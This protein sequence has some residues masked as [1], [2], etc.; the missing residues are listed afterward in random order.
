MA[1]KFYLNDAAASYNPGVLKGAWND[2][3]DSG[4]IG[5]LGTS[6]SGAYVTLGVAETNTSP[7]WNVYLASFVS[8]ALANNV[9]FKTTDTLTG[10]LAV[11]VSNAAAL[12]VTHIHIWVTVGNSDTVRGT[13]LNDSIGSSDWPT[14]TQGLSLGTLNL[15]NNVNALTGDHIVVEIGY[16]AQNTVATSYTGTLGFGANSPANPDLTNGDTSV[17]TNPSWIQFST[18]FTSTLTFLGSSID[19]NS[20]PHSVTVTP[21]PNDLIVIVTTATNNTSN[22]VP[23]DDNTHGGVYEQITNA[24]KNNGVDKLAAYVRTEFIQYT[25]S[26]TFTHDPGTSSGG[27]IAVYAIRGSAK[28]GLAAIKQSIQDSNKLSATPSP[29]LGNTPVSTNPVLSAVFNNTNPGGVTARTGYTSDLDTGYATPTSGFDSIHLNSGETSATIT[30]GSSSASNYC[31]LA[32]EFDMSVTLLENQQDTFLGETIL[33]DTKWYDNTQTGGIQSV[34]ST[35]VTLNAPAFTGNALAEVESQ[36]RYDLTGSHAF[37]KATITQVADVN[38]EAV[39]TI[40]HD[41]YG[42]Q[43]QLKISNSNLVAGYLIAG[44]ETDVGTIAY[45]ATTMAY[46]RIRESSGTIYWDYSADGVTW[47]N[48]GS[49]ATSTITW[50][51]TLVRTS[52]ATYNGDSSSTDEIGIFSNF[53]IA[54]TVPTVVTNSITSI[55]QLDAVGNGDV[56]LDGGATITERGF[57]LSTITN[58]TTSDTKFVVTGTTG[59]FTISLTPLLSDTVYH[60]RAY[61]INSQGTSYGADVAFNT[62]SSTVQAILNPINGIG[63][64]QRSKW[65]V[66]AWVNGQLFADLTGIANDRHLVLIRNDSDQIDFSMNLDQLEEYARDIKVNSQDILQAGITEIRFLRNGTVISAGY[67]TYWDVELAGDRKITIQA[68]GWLEKLKYRISNNQYSSQTALQIFQAEVN[69]TQALA[70]GNLGL[71]FGALP[72]SDATNLFGVKT[73]QDK[74]LYDLLTDFTKEDNGFD[75]QITWDKKINI[76]YPTMGIIRDDVVFSYPGNIKDIK[77]S[78][79]VTKWGNEFIARGSGTGLN[80]VDLADVPSKQKYGLQQALANFSDVDNQN[81]L[82]DLTQTELNLFK[83]PVILHDVQMDGSIDPQFG[84]YNLGDQIRISVSNL[85]KLYTGVNGFFKID[86]IDVKIGS[87]DDETIEVSTNA[88]V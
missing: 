1:Q 17:T 12:D 79:D 87:A 33:D 11:L 69:A 36:F 22:A 66:Q 45:N 61:A 37:V 7:T 64:S 24:V 15:S 5:Q 4:D 41:E 59:T 50:G 52:V 53:N 84:T 31:D 56:L 60:C 34:G 40:Y 57:V 20:G 47:T 38:A 86:K 80:D 67:I 83:V 58:P 8:D 88:P 76:Y 32:I 73:Y 30:W 77:V 19:T 42:N 65:E 13:L 26:T 6:P 51:I 46:I 81:Q 48:L 75:F 44:T 2:T 35:G 74:L 54:L 27:G 71:V 3:S 29:V 62:L 63:K 39:L 78:N 9:S 23:V 25:V 18:D 70:Y 82:Q 85:L 21:L 43:L 16:Q 55:E 49:V 72:A 68:R 28:V 10:V 14:T